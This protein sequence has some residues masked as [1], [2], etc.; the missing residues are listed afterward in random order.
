M[1][2]GNTYLMGR[3]VEGV[4]EESPEDSLSCIVPNV[5]SLFYVELFM[6][7]SNLI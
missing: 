2:P 6:Y 4:P 7:L 3:K 1:F 5:T